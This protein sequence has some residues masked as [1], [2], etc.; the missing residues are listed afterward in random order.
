MEIRDVNMDFEYR[1]SFTEHSPEAHERLITDLLIGDANLF[2]GC[3]EVE[4]VWR[5]LDPIEEHWAA[6][7]PP[8]PYRPGTWG[9]EQADRLL[10]RDGSRWR[11]P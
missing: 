1:D 9:A 11:R 4:Q 7:S 8:V 10:A 5:I 6:G 2:P 3:E